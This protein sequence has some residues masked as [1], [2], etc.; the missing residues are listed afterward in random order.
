MFSPWVSL[1]HHFQNP[2][3]MDLSKSLSSFAKSLIIFL[4]K[5]KNNLMFE[6]SSRLN[7][8]KKVCVG[9]VNILIIV[10]LTN[11]ILNH[12]LIKKSRGSSQ[13]FVNSEQASKI[14]AVDY[15]FKF[16][17]DIEVCLLQFY[18]N[19]F[20]NISFCFPALSPRRYY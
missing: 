15:L 18:F 12:Q 1:H 6:S 9:L 13:Q 17:E 5:M 11:V 7:K 4:T 16:C 20:V 2:C 3:R 8:R 14:A 10:L 19:K